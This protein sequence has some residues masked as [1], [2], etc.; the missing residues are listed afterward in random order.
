[1]VASPN[2]PAPMPHLVL[3]IAPDLPPIDGQALLR[4]LH[5]VL[6]DTGHF[7][8]PEIKGRIL[9]PEASR[10]GVDSPEETFVHLELRVMPGRP[11]ELL[12]GLAGRLVEVLDAAIPRLPGKRL[13]V[14]AEVLELAPTRYAKQ[15]R[16][17]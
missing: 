10:V 5:Q 14:T 7:R 9:R 2:L 11:P 16:T 6:V 17:G 4:T 8:A 1:M 13:Q 12:S 3:E 15:W